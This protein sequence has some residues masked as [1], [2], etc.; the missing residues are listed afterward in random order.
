[1]MN[2]YFKLFCFINFIIV[3]GCCK[4]TVVQYENE[5]TWQDEFNIDGSPNQEIWTRSSVKGDSQLSTYCPSDSNAYVKEG[6]LHLVVHKTNNHELQYSAG[7]VIANKNYH[8]KRGKLVVR[9]KAPL[10]AGLWPAIW[11]RGPR[12]KKGYF[13]EIDLLEHVKAMGDS[14]YEVTYHLWGNFDGKEHNHKT[15]WSDVLINVGEWHVY[16]LEILQDQIIISVDDNTMFKLMKGH[17]GDI[18]PDDQE[19]SLRLA[20][21]YG[22]FGAKKYGIDDSALPAEF[23]ID[24]VRFYDVKAE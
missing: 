15:F 19:Y 12:N 21:A 10:S 6:Y 13:A 18:W 20:L 14:S 4:T 11:L 23:L 24:Y 1:M 2:L 9:A 8:F 3:C 7:R 17:Y 5:P 22:G 16:S